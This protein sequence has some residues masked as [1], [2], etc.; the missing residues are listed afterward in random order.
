VT[1]SQE[2]SRRHEARLKPK[3]DA[4]I[5]QANRANITVYPLDAAGLRVHSKEMELGRNVN[6]AGAQ[7]VGDERRGDGPWTN[8][9][10]KQDQLLSSR[11]GA[12]LGRLAR[13]TG[14]FLLENTNALGAGAPT[15]HH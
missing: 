3:F 11:P 1:R 2:E 14:G 10:E 12:A 7:G 5:G 15:S 13:E 8:D 6:V 4:L 9:L